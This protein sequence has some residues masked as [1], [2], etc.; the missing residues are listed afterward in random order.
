MCWFL[1]DE[2][3]VADTV[4]PQE[5]LRSIEAVGPARNYDNEVQLLGSTQLLPTQG[6]RRAV[7]VT[8][9]GAD[10][11]GGSFVVRLCGHHELEK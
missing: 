10:S 9:A 11:F 4:L 1:L 5:C 7:T 8:A 2:T 3:L 6:P